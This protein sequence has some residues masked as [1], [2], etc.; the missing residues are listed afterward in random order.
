MA[1]KM[2]TVAEQ[3]S[4]GFYA[5]GLYAAQKWCWCDQKSS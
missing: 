1:V 5:Y 2:E 3:L 4:D